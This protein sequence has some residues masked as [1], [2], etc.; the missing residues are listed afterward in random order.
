MS[1]VSDDRPQQEPETAGPQPAGAVDLDFPT[2]GRLVD[3]E[4]KGLVEQAEYVHEE[5]M[6]LTTDFEWESATSV[7]DFDA[8]I[9]RSIDE[10]VTLL[11]GV[12]SSAYRLA[13]HVRTLVE[14]RHVH[15]SARGA[16]ETGQ[17]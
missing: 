13:R 12:G 2:L 3:A 17:G 6:D 7:L 14:F 1:T 10:L 8:E 15:L 5:L 11:N 9:P 4:A 16:R